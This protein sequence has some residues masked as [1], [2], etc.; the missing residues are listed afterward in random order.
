LTCEI[1]VARTEE[2]ILM[3][4]VRFSIAGLMVVV[5]VTAVV[6]AALRSASDAWAGAM[7]MLVCG[8]LGLAIVGIVCRSGI[9]RT[10]WLG[11]A[12]F[13]C[14]YLVLAFWSENNFNRLPTATLTLFLSSKFDPTIK[15][16]AW[17]GGGS[18]HWSFSQIAHCVWALLAA[19]LGGALASV[20]F[21]GPEHHRKRPVVETYPGGQLPPIWRRGPAVIWL[22]GLAIVALA[23]LAG[24]RT[25]PGLWAGVVFLLTCGMFGL[26]IL[27][28]LVG[29]GSRWTMWLGAAL[30]GCGY[31]FFT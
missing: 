20:L 18:L 2:A 4:R 31:M 9:E 28:A 24:S 8:V 11:F 13:G 23:A 10:W 15:Q 5:A 7:L 1:E 3:R 30:F 22:A 26:A 14:G 17:P 16:G 12:L 27:G 29:R 19:I 21:A 6:V 25:A